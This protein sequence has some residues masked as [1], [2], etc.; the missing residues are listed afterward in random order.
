MWS[1]ENC[2]P[3]EYNGLPKVESKSIEAEHFQ[4][5][6][7]CSQRVMGPKKCF[8]LVL[9]KPASAIEKIIQMP[10]GGGKRAGAEGKPQGKLERGGCRYHGQPRRRSVSAPRRASS[11]DF[12]ER[13]EY[14]S[15]LNSSVSVGS[16][17]RWGGTFG[18]GYIFFFTRFSV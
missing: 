1:V 13:E 3:E 18:G 12:P 15:L 10:R 4:V 5:L 9:T 14:C 2:I 16:L 7:I 8:K 11:P 6:V 17:R